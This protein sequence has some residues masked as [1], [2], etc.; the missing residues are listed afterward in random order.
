MLI[1]QPAAHPYK[2]DEHCADDGETKK[3]KMIRER[4]VFVGGKRQPLRQKE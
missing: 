2:S 1:A 4:D 3:K